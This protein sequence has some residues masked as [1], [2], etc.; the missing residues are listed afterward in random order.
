MT[1]HRVDIARPP[2]PPEMPGYPPLPP[3]PPADR[4][5]RW[6]FLVAA[7]AISAV[8]AS[9]AAV[10]ITIQAQDTTATP[11]SPTRETI[12]VAAPTPAAPAPLPTTE[13]DHQTCQVGF[14][15]T[16]APTKAAAQALALLPP[17][18]KVLDPAVQA[19]PDW[20]A[21][22]R[23]AGDFYKQASDALRTQIAPGT[24]PVLAQAANAAVSAFQ[25]LGNAYRDFD[26]IAGNAHDIALAAS[27]Q[28]V[29]L[30]QRLAP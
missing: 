25:V 6:P 17:G 12:T 20:A 7:A 1:Y 28:M 10:A 24:T 26:P 2:T 23:R 21:A 15:G 19:N 8:V 11:G 9:A 14:V 3:D 5:R 16:Q 13:A 22:V 29:T 4:N 27:D 18:V 30:C